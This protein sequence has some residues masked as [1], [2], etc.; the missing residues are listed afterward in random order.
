MQT[1]IKNQELGAEVDGMQDLNKH[2]ASVFR[3]HIE[4]IRNFENSDKALEYLLDNA[5][6]ELHTLNTAKIAYTN[7][8]EY[9]MNSL[10][11]NHATD[12]Q[13]N[14]LSKISE[15]IDK[16][17]KTKGDT[18]EAFMMDY[19]KRN[20]AIKIE[21]PEPY[22]TSSEKTAEKFTIMWF[23]EPKGSTFTQ[24]SGGQFISMLESVV[25]VF[26]LDKVL[27]KSKIVIDFAI[28]SHLIKLENSN[29]LTLDVIINLSSTQMRFF[30]LM[31]QMFYKNGDFLKLKESIKG[32]VPLK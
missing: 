32:K 23:L 4:K 18:S 2:L 1:D 28:N 7:Q 6:N 13:I 22:V 12:W 8:A 25:D 29:N 10:S 11:F 19:L 9:F 27:E 26:S 5:D 21:F 14:L 17:I 24:E 20:N 31:L 30:L 3:C 15:N 16:Y